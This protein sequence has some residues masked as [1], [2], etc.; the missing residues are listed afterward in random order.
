MNNGHAGPRKE[1][2]DPQRMAVLRALPLEIKQ[3]ITG[4]EAQAFIYKEELPESL[5]EKLKDYLENID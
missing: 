1:K 5:L 2:P 3:L 4:E